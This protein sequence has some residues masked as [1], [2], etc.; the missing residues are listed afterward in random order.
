MYRKSISKVPEGVMPDF[1]ITI[2]RRNEK[3]MKQ[4]I[5][6]GKRFSVERKLAINLL[7]FFHT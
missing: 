7:D 6:T 5:Q 2:G 3:D 1:T 4:K